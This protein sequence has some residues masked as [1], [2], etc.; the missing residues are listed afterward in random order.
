MKLIY[1]PECKDM[2]AIHPGRRRYCRC[3]ASS[4]KYRPDGWHADAYGRAIMLG[5]HNGQL[6]FM[7]NGLNMP[8]PE[9]EPMN[10][11]YPRK[12]YMTFEIFVQ[13]RWHPQAHYHEEE[14]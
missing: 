5:F 6:W 14:L 13:P 12:A 8:K 1:C 7:E 11:Q 10:S 2:L 3:K 9:T 4:G